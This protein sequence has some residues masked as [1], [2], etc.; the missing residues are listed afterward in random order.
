LDTGVET[1][2][3]ALMWPQQASGGASK[4]ADIGRRGIIAVADIT[5]GGHPAW[6]A[7]DHH[8]SLYWVATMPYKSSQT[9]CFGIDKAS[10]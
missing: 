5:T 2:T 3:P 9:V 8:S 10:S 4:I 7:F 1:E 6:P